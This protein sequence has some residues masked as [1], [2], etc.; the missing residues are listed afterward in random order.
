MH[1]DLILEALSQL[2]I[3]DYLA[4]FEESLVQRA[5]EVEWVAD[6]NSPDG[7]SPEL[8][9]IFLLNILKKNKYGSN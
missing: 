1:K 6:Q 8:R 5:T 4:L 2:T 9:I 3:G 7:L